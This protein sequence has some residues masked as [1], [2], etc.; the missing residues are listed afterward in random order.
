MIQRKL[1]NRVRVIC[2][3]L[4]VWVVRVSGALPIL[5]RDSSVAYF[6]LD[7]G[8]RSALKTHAEP[9]GRLS[10]RLYVNAG[11]LMESEDQR[12]LAHFLE[13]MAFNGTRHFEPEAMVE[14]FQRLGM[15]FGG[16]TNAYTSWDRTVYMLELPKVSDDYI[17]DALKLLRDYADGMLLESEQLDKERG[18]ILSE[19]RDRDTVEFR[20]YQAEMNFLFPQAI[21]PQRFPI[22]DE[23]VIQ[24]AT[25]DTFLS[26][27][28]SWYQPSRMVL[29]AVGDVAT[30]KLQRS[31]ETYFG[32][33]EPS[34]IMT[35]PQIGSVIRPTKTIALHRDS[36]APFTTIALEQIR[37]SEKQPDSPEKRFD[38]LQIDLVNAILNQ[39]LDRL[40]EQA[41][42]PIIKGVAYSNDFLNEAWNVGLESSCRPEQWDAALNLMVEAWQQMR[43]FGPNPIE[44]NEMKRRTLQAFADAVKQAP[45]QKSKDLSNQ[46]LQSIADRTVFQSPAQALEWIEAVLPGITEATAL[47][48]WNRSW[49][50]QTPL[51]W[52]SGNIMDVSVTESRIATVLETAIEKEVTVPVTEVLS[53]FAYADIGPAGTIAAEVTHPDLGITQWTL[54]NGVRI[55]WKQTDFA[56]DQILLSFRWGDGLLSLPKTYSGLDKVLEGVW[57]RGGLESHPYSEIERMTAGRSVAVNFNISPDAFMLGGSCSKAD[58]LFQLQLMCA[59]F[60]HPGLRDEGWIQARKEIEAVY[61]RLETTAMGAMEAQVK[62]FLASGDPRFQYPSLSQ[63]LDYSNKEARQWIPMSA[64]ALEVAIV[65]DIDLSV[66]TPSILETLGALSVRSAFVPPSADLRTLQFPAS[67]SETFTFQSEIPKALVGVYWPTDDIWNIRETRRL[68]L[69]ASI[70]N[71]RLRKTIREELGDA[72]SPQAVSQRSDAFEHYGFLAALVSVDPE[73]ISIVAEKVKEIAAELNLG[74][75]SEDELNRAKEPILKQLP[76]LRRNNAYWLQSV[77]MSAQQYPQRIDWCRE[78]ETD[79]AAINLAEIRE[80][81]VAYLL[82]ATAVTV[83]IVPA[84]KP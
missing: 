39:R 5:E 35:D 80:L 6:T 74:Q 31:I 29:V 44:L 58:F 71:D 51:V 54:A 3:L 67:G 33:M 66:L 9:T 14:Y 79:I 47:E 25:R 63:I 75:I 32:D 19:K 24:Q 20:A 11:S 7:N 2:L 60:E 8:F 72:Y 16:D 82:D 84:S 26:Y 21:F 56:K 83:Q 59:Y 36:E 42:A 4:V 48:S 46:L 23:S 43:R 15:S 13:H 38:Q 50:D 64:P 10:L 41:D 40:T 17:D 12:G 49:G 1:M 81:A 76:E 22:G 62:P 57:I 78:M 18:V 68:Q 37:A 77:L 27:Y 34:G 30:D 55:N 73:K 65:G 69:L 52:V 53:E 45:T 70:F 28:Q 61:P